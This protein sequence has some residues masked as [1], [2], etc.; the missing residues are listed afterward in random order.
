[1][2]LILGEEAHKMVLYFSKKIKYLLILVAFL[3]APVS[4]ANEPLVVVV[5]KT[6]EISQLSKKQVIDIY[7]GRYLS[8]PDGKSV[9]P[10]DFPANSD[11]KQSFYLMLVNQSER[12]IKSYW[13]RLLFSGRA[14][15]PIEAKSQENAI[16]LVEQTSDAIAYLLRE[17]VT[18][19]MKIVYQF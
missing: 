1:M 19:E 17:Q 7:M 18:S 15:P 9:S 12:K 5:N 14:K 11:I 6:N 13:S 8:F 16:F 10:I 4:L 2:I 3:F